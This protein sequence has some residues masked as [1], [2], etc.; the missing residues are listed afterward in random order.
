MAHLVKSIDTDGMN[1]FAQK[2]VQTPSISTREGE[3][4]ALT[5]E[6]MRRAG[7]AVTVDRMGNVIG[8]IGTGSGQRLLYDAHMDTVDVGDLSLIHI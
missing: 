8:R 1:A 6:E 3:V 7:F 4:A 5:A 2:L